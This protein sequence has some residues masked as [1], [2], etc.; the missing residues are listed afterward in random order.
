MRIKGLKFTTSKVEISLEIHLTWPVP[1]CKATMT[2]RRALVWFRLRRTQEVLIQH[3]SHQ[4]IAT[5]RVSRNAVSTSL[6]SR[7]NHLKK[8]MMFATAMI[9]LKSLLGERLYMISQILT[10]WTAE[11]SAMRRGPHWYR[12][13]WIL[14]RASCH[15]WLRRVRLKTRSE[16]Q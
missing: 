11:R 8:L 7:W 15:L 4:A 5:T 10:S 1:E 9:R 16:I 2:I 6:T 12:H 14:K 3:Y 13:L